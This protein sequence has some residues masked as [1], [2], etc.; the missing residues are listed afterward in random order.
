M[1][2]LTGL[3]V[4][5]CAACA[6][7]LGGATMQPETPRAT[8]SP[9]ALAYFERMMRAHDSTGIEQAACVTRWN[10]AVRDGITTMNILHVA[11]ARVLNA[12]HD[13][14]TFECGARDGTVHTHSFVCW[15]SETD[16]EGEEAFGVVVCPRP[17][18]F[19]VFDVVARKP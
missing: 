7:T 16:R 2:L 17:T 1:R 9:Q 4:V 13:G 5:V 8:A 18:R 6:A 14:V 12:V 11:P 15:P 10:F 3:L 19:A